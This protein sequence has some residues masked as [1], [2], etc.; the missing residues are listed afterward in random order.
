MMAQPKNSTQ[1]FSSLLLFLLALGLWQCELKTRFVPKLPQKAAFRVSHLGTY[2][3]KLAGDDQKEVQGTIFQTTLSFT[4]T[5]SA[6]PAA[7]GAAG[8]LHRHLDTLI[9]RGYHKLSMPH[10]LEK[11]VDIDLW[12][13]SNLVPVKIAG[14]DSLKAVLGRIQQKEDYKKQL[15]ASSSSARFE[16]EDRDW[17]RV[18]G[19]LPKGVELEPRKPVPVEAVNKL[20]EVQKL[21]SARFEGPQPRGTRLDN[22]KSCLEFTVYYHRPDSLGLLVEQFFFSGTQNRKYRRHTW[23]P[24]VVQ[25]AERFS[26]DKAT[27]FPCFHSKTESADIL[28]QRK[29]KEEMSE[30]PIQL[31][32]YEEDIYE[33]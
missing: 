28:L 6:S 11:K 14:Y 32:R 33:Y 16:A 19:L 13:D 15:L 10:E 31:F 8:I 12:L 20:L 7:P 27:G 17:W 3:T 30:L 25:G 4:W 18:A 24:G 21:D 23:K 26:V 1:R 29:D 2:S 5:A 22:K 9:A